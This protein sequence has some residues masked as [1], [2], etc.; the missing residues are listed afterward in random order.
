M[1]DGEDGIADAPE[2]DAVWCERVRAR[3]VDWFAGAARDLPWRHD[4]DAYRVLVSE[5]M[6]V[7]TTVAAVVPYFQRFLARFPSVADLAAADEAEVLRLWEGLGY[8]RRCR[9]LHQAARQIVRDHGGTLPADPQAIRRLPGVGPYVAGAVLSLAY[10][11]P[12]PILE[13]NSRR[14][15]ARLLAWPGTLGE[16]ATERRLW[17]AARALVPSPGAAAFNEALMELGATLCTP[18]QP[19]CLVCPLARECHAHA[20]GLQDILPKK[21]AKEPPRLGEEAAVVVRRSGGLVLI[22]QRAAKG[23]W[24]GFWEFPTLHRGGADPAGRG[25]SEGQEIAEALRALTGIAATVAPAA[26]TLHFGVTRHRV[27]LAVHPARYRA[28]K[29]RPGP[30]LDRAIWEQPSALADYPF[31]SAQRGIA[32]RLAAGEEP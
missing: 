23:L 4:R 5:M 15:L 13:A 22:V 17:R 12:E 18:R 10:D 29:A 20:A 26:R 16:P 14:V 32:A 31:G 25:P 21:A 19:A 30:G 7:Q 27:C 6:L 3:L 8:Y 2:A 1:G 28:G 9:Q 24:A 11:R